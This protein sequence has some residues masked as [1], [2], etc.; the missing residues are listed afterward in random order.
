MVHHYA[1]HAEQKASHQR[2]SHI[3][4]GAQGGQVT[5]LRSSPGEL[6]TRIDQMKADKQ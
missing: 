6:E 3:L 5:G 4:K 1:K 2:V